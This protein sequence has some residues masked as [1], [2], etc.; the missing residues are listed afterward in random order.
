M[1]RITGVPLCGL[2]L[3]PAFMALIIAGCG[4]HRGPGTIEG[5]GL[6]PHA[7]AGRT[8]VRSG[9]SG[10]LALKAETAAP[11]KQ[12][13]F[14]DLHVHTTYSSDA[15]L[16]SLPMLQGDG[17]HPVSDACDYARY[18]S[19][20]DFWSINDHAE[21]IT[22]RNWLD[23]KES[24]RQCNALAG[25][26]ENPDM[27]SFLGWEW[28]EAGIVRQDHYGHKNVIFVDT[29]ED[30]VPRRPVHA[31]GLGWQF[32]RQKP[33]FAV[34]YLLPLS[35]FADRQHY[36]D[37]VRFRA[38]LRAVPPCEEGVDARELPDD[39]QEIAR[40]P[41]VLFE[42]LDQWGFDSI[43]IPHGN[44][45]GMYTPTHSTWHKQLAGSNRG[46]DKQI[47]IE[48]F[49]GHGNS[50]EYRSWRP[51]LLDDE[52]QLQCPEA[53]DEF[54]PCC[55]QAGEIIR[56]RCE[57]AASEQCQGAVE[58]ARADYIANNLAGRTMT[59]PGT[60]LSGWVDCGTCRD[61]YLPSFNYRPS[62]SVQA[63]VA[64][65]HFEA[66]GTPKRFRFGFMASSDNHT[67]RPG[68]GYK[69]FAR[70]DVTE[71]RGASTEAQARRLRSPRAFEEPRV[72]SMRL[73]LSRPEE[74]PM[75]LG[76][77]DF[78]RQASFFMSG[79]LVAVHSE[80]RART[81]VWGALKR[82]EIYG[83]S[84]P[85]ILLWFDLLNAGSEPAVMGS[86]VVMS[87]N[88]RF[89][90]RAL[91]SLEQR[92]GCPQIAVDGLST[93]RLEKLCQNECYN[94]GDQ[95]RAI[96][97]IEVTRIRPQVSATEP[98][99]GLIDDPWRVFECPGDGDG[100]VVEFDD[101]AYADQNREVVYY[102]RA[103]EEPSLGVNA[104]QLRCTYDEDG[105]CV[106]VSPCYGDYRTD[107]DDDCLA[108]N[109]E[110]AW[111]SPIYVRKK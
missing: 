2:V 102:V 44:T 39:C 3:A 86:E 13:L 97:R 11:A 49:S 64:S 38:D 41:G 31:G 105:N 28:T 89:R 22:P 14:G 24:I 42:K 109:E 75:T 35:E 84:G 99:D 36:F 54:L 30:K 6:P 50:E 61:C 101:P 80:G 73:D 52:G 58:K 43:V 103:I 72:E 45:W 37:F 78:E 10:A 93:E 92:P 63:A 82:K 104:G 107:Y 53:T 76:I 87:E 77:A 15:F 85:R 4:K 79:G 7:V 47:M 68:T 59:L 18:C 8:S 81:E 94:P 70:F 20:L 74:I 57:D 19:A 100:C 33:N 95:R 25:D 108:P 110:R 34:R 40:T 51:E 32:M 69:E 17:A 55:W 9:A 66:D 60:E 106:E 12:I 67:G 90:V 62:S 88:P 56:S 48:V 71:A 26:P 27:V 111:S 83:T 91:G 46:P 96:T 29:A 5:A 98:I 1:R 65:T 21:S 16:M 23:T